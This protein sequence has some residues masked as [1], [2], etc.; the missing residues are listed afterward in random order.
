MTD[1]AG[2]DTG[3]WLSVVGIGEDGLDGLAPAARALVEAAEILVGGDRHLAMVPPD[4]R[5]RL[6]WPSPLAALL[7]ALAERAGRRV[8]VLATGDPM[9][10]GVGVTLARRFGREAMTVVPGVSAFCLAAARLGWPLAEVTCLTLHGRPLELVIPALQPGAR[11]LALSH[12][13]TTP[14]AVADRLRRHG[15]GPS[16][17]VALAHMGGPQEQRI[18]ATADTWSAKEVSDFNTLAIE[19]EATPQARPL[20]CVPGLPDDAFVHDGKLTKR[21]VR[22]A[23]L[24][25]LA[26]GPGQV[27]WDVGAGCGSV[28]VEWLRAA[29]HGTAVAIEPVADRRAMIAQNALALGTPQLRVVDGRAPDCLAD[30]PAPDAVFVGGGITAPRVVEACWAALAPGGRLVANVV[31]LEGEAEALAWHKRLGGELARIA[32]SRA[33]PVGPFEGWKHQMTVTQLA[34]TKPW[35]DGGGTR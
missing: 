4:G 6:A 28:A 33:E 9:H 15:W 20:P 35:P 11:I 24:A 26:P 2:A 16:R 13:G 29:P 12:D 8:C 21:A 30:L 5:E 22:A 31:T 19:L 3:R 17:L 25:M 14:A 32:V 34:A 27:L 23:T 1:A 18:D 10:Y 7:D